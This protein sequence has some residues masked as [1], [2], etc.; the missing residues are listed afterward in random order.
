MRRLVRPILFSERLAVLCVAATLAVSLA[1][2]GTGAAR[3]GSAA[4]ASL[5]P[6][7]TG[8][9][10]P[11]TA[12]AGRTLAEMTE[13]QRVGQLFLLGIDGNELSREE[14]A[15]IVTNHFGSTLLVNARTGGIETDRRLAAAIQDL[16]TRPNTDGVRFFV[17]ADQEGGRVQRLTGPGFATMPSALEQGG[18]APATLQQDAVQWGSSLRAAGV[19]L[20]L[21]PVM[22]V[23]PPGADATNE[24]IG[25]LQRE[26]GHDPNTVG[27]HGAAV[28]RGMAQAGVA[29]T[30]KHFP[31]LGRVVG[32]T[33]TVAGV[34]DTVTT[35]DDPYLAAFRA[36]IAA[37][38]P[39]VMVSLATYSAIDPDHQAVFSQKIVGGLL[40]GRLGFRGV[41]MSDDLGSTTSVA[42]MAPGDRA[43]T[44]IEAGGEF[45][46][47]EGV[48][49][50]DAMAAAVLDRAEANSGFATDVS[51]A[52]LHVLQA[53]AAAGLLTCG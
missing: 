4:P 46:V 52:A 35:A 20:D 5:A 42:S 50:A 21:A 49:A 28:I 36:G 41:I 17:A 13:Q 2:C 47:V 30:L 45:I 9:T 1:A 43:T 14:T 38:A 6:D 19:N 27:D 53:K 22:D 15:A 12:C 34:S 51:A 48:D 10:V 26:Y 7:L 39:F 40:R 33:D 23:V 37:G 3:P 11:A 32:N 44:F 24:P 8:P 29:T 18:L 25:A 31:G 16:A